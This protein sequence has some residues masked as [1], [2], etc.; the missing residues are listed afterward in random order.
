MAAVIEDK[1]KGNRHTFVGRYKV[2]CAGGSGRYSRDR[3]KSTTPFL[4][5]KTN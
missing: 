2:V 4:F 1:G 3:V 5:F